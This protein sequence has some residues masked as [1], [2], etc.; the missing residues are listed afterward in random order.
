MD[1]NTILV[2]LKAGEYERS[3]DVYQDL[4]LIIANCLKYNRA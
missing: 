3:E 4:E 1:L 2:K